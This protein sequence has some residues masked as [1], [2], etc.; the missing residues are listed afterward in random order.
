MGDPKRLSPV[1]KAEEED[2]RERDPH[3]RRVQR[4]AELALVTARHR[5]R[6]LR[7]R[8]GLD[9]VAASAVDVDLDDLVVVLGEEADLPAPVVAHL[10]ARA[11]LP[12]LC[13]ELGDLR[14]LG[15]DLKRLAPGDRERL[16]RLRI[17][18]GRRRLLGVRGRSEQRAACKNQRQCDYLAQTA[19]ASDPTDPMPKWST[20]MVAPSSSFVSGSARL[21]APK[22]VTSAAC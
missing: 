18:N 14:L 1:E 19:Y 5:P 6:D 16:G 2:E 7:S 4:V 3:P 13:R 8:P 9:G 21:S 15:G 11:E 22:M 12:D 17:L 10:L 20:V